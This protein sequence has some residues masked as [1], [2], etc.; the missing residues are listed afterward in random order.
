MMMDMM[1]EVEVKPAKK[2]RM[3]KARICGKRLTESE[4]DEN[5]E[6]HKKSMTEINKNFG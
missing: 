4:K 6:I 3:K 1:N 5:A 2:K